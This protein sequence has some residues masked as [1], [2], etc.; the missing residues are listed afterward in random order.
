M[1]VRL[2]PSAPIHR[3][4][5][6]LKR[7]ENCLLNR[8][9]SIST[10]AD[11][12]QGVC[13]SEYSTLPVAA[14]LRCGV[15][16]VRP[17]AAG[18]GSSSLPITSCF[19]SGDG[20][21]GHWKFSVTRLN[22]HL[23]P[24][25]AACGGLVVVDA[26]RRGKCAPDSFS[27]TVPVWCCVM[28]RIIARHRA[29]S[30][31]SAAASTDA[32]RRR[33][34]EIDSYEDC[35]FEFC[36]SAD[37]DDFAGNQWGSLPTGEDEAA[38]GAD[39]SGDTESEDDEHDESCNHALQQDE[40]AMASVN[41]QWSELFLPSWVSASEAQ[42]LLGRIDLWYF[43]RFMSCSFDSRGE[44]FIFESCF[45][46]LR[47]CSALEAHLGSAGIADLLGLAEGL[48]R[49]LRPAWVRPDAPYPKWNALRDSGFTPV[50]CVS[51][52]REITETTPL[53]GRQGWH[54]IPG[55]GDDSDNWSVALS[56]SVFWA[57]EAALLGAEHSDECERIATRLVCEA[58]APTVGVVDALSPSLS[59]AAAGMPLP[60]AAHTLKLDGCTFLVGIVLDARRARVQFP[61][62]FISTDADCAPA[63]MVSSSSASM[64]A[65]A[66]SVAATSLEQT[67]HC[68][69]HLRIIDD[70]RNKHALESQLASIVEFAAS[71]LCAAPHTLE[72]R[73]VLSPQ[74][75]L[76]VQA[77]FSVAIVVLAAV[78]LANFD[79]RLEAY[80]GLADLQASVASVSQPAPLPAETLA[81]AVA[82]PDSAPA[83]EVS[84]RQSAR[85]SGLPQSLTKDDVRRALGILQRAIPQTLPARRLLQSLNRFLMPVA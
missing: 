32:N 74:Q 20:H 49:P 17:A 48:A 67:Q 2:D 45:R 56:A 12:V 71:A 38:K 78:L 84:A 85:R 70:K 21:Y 62:L 4:Y 18:A 35:G 79:R 54:Y 23:L 39:G 44:S 8:L 60:A 47:R 59:V 7:G 9:K 83:S 25:L 10:D 73:M 19:K 22:L 33:D 15:W 42:Q 11:F 52:S 65:S 3:L 24:L 55:A 57:N 29:G 13:Q 77:D 69:L 26:T 75:A 28:N 53:T 31:Q 66:A 81:S 43:F 58:A 80:T 64:S 76:A 14:N 82:P 72:V 6:E 50:V 51:A 34:S 27:K 68:T 63:D 41:N 36:S 37:V 16:Y 46:L 61:T 1:S 30:N 40:R 5:R